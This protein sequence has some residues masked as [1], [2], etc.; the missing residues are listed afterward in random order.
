MFRST[1]MIRGTLPLVA[2]LAASPAFAGDDPPCHEVPAAP[3]A[4]TREQA[5]Y[6]LP[7]IT[8]VDQTGKKVPVRSLLAED[9]A[10]ALNFIFATCTTICPVMTATFSQMRTELGADVK[11]VKTVSITIDPEHDTPA[12]LREYAAK[13]HAPADWQF[14]T[15]STADVEAVLRA[16]DAWTGSKLAHQPIT[17]LHAPGASQWVRLEGLGGGADLA[18]ETR[19]VI[20]AAGTR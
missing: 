15:G 19:K 1:L 9:R 6:P 18:A 8:L 11:R 17:L 13:F 10:V 4:F 20:G 5:A 14:L 2:L 16:F 7:D 3:S 12:V